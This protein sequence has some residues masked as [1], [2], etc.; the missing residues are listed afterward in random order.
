MTEAAEIAEELPLPVPPFESRP[1]PRLGG[2]VTVR[3]IPHPLPEGEVKKLAALAAVMKA[4]RE[5]GDGVAEMD[6]VSDLDKHVALLRLNIGV[7]MSRREFLLAPETPTAP[8][9]TTKPHKAKKS[10]TSG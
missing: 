2:I 1:S 7:D 3:V 6:S 9:K 10:I 5:S 8:A 4:A